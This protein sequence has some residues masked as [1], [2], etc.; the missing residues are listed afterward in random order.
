MFSN[1]LIDLSTE[2]TPLSDELDA[3]TLSNIS[4]LASWFQEEHANY[5]H[6]PAQPDETTFSEIYHALV[7]SNALDTLLQLE[8]TSTIAVAELTKARANA[9]EQL[10]SKQRLQMENALNIQSS[11]HNINMLARDHTQEREAMEVRWESE[12][13]QMIDSQKREYREFV[14]NLHDEMLDQQLS[15][16]FS[17]NNNRRSPAHTDNVNLDLAR[18]RNEALRS[19]LSAPALATPPLIAESA[20]RLQESFT[21]NLGE[22]S[23]FLNILKVY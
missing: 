2:T 15:S 16:E 6:V 4:C 20:N 9:M 17:N 19:I 21:I 1:D 3:P 13:S 11:D 22:L 14:L 5:A 7:N 12:V 10:L 23:C 18:S 8:H